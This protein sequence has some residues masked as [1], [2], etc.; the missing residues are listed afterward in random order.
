LELVYRPVN[1]SPTE[2]DATVQ[3]MR[4]RMENLGAR[5]LVQRQGDVIVVKLDPR[6]NIERVKRIIGK[7]AKLEFVLVDDSAEANAA[8]EQMALPPAV[9]VQ[10]TSWSEHDRNVVHELVYFKAASRAPLEVL[11][12]RVPPRWRLGIEHVD[13]SEQGEEWNGML[14][15]KTSPLGGND[16]TDASVGWD[17]EMNRPE[18]NIEFDHEG[19]R[20]IEKF[21]SENIGRKLAILFDGAIQSAPIIES[22][23]GARIRITLGSG[24]PMQLQTEAKDMVGTLRSAALPVPVELIR[25]ENK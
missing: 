22:K 8:A 13:R 1:A 17:K 2:I 15:A 11:A 7:Q 10:K 6:T 19:A 9:T 14:L 23:L 3:I 4:G 24:E 18:V 25:M 5:G 20:V 12:G 21:S 16:L